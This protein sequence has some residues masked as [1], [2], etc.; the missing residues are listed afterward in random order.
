VFGLLLG[1][2]EILVILMVLAFWLAVIGGVI[3]IVLSVNK[4]AKHKPVTAPVQ[5]PAGPPPVATKTEIIPQKCP[6]CGTP[7]PTGALAGLCPACLLKLGAAADTVTDAKQ[8]AFNPPTV[9]ELAPLFPQL[10]ILELIGKGGMGAVYKARQKQLDR[11]VA[12]KILPPGIGDDPAFAERF[13]RE[14]KALAKLNHPGIVTLYEFG[15]VGRAGSP[16]PAAGGLPTDAGAHGVTRSTSE[17]ASGHQPSTL[18][19]QLFYFLMEFVDGVNL[20]QLLAGSRISAR[21]ALAIVPQIC[22]ALQFAHDQGIV[23]RDIKPE[24]ILMDRRGRVKVADFGLAKI[25]GTERGS[26]SRSG[27]EIEGAHKQP[28]APVT[29]Q[30]AADHRPAL[31]ELTDA[32]KVMGTP[33]YMSPEQIH[34]PGEVDH[35][36]DIYA[37]GVV[38]YQML[39]GE[40]PGKKLEAPS[41]KVQID[42]RLDEIVLRALEKKPELRYQQV[43]EV[44]TMVET[45]VATPDSSR[46]RGD[47]SQTSQTPDTKSQTPCS[48]SLLTSSPTNQ[49]A[50]FSRTA[51]FGACWTLLLILCFIL[52]NVGIKTFVL[53]PIG[54]LAVIGTTI[55]GWVAVA[56]I[57]RSAGKLHGLWLAVFDGLLFPLLALD[58]L[59]FVAVAFGLRFAGLG[60]KRTSPPTFPLSYLLFVAVII[61]ILLLLD[62]LIIR[63]VWHAVNQPAEI[64]TTESTQQKAGAARDIFRQPFAQV[65]G[66]RQK[67]DRFWRWFAVVVFAMV[68]IPFLISIVGL[69]AAIAIPSFVKARVKAQENAEMARQHSDRAAAWTDYLRLNQIIAPGVTGSGAYGDANFRYEVLF[70]ETSVALTVTYAKVTGVEYRVQTEDKAGKKQELE[71]KPH[72]TTVRPGDGQPS[73]E[74]KLMLSRTEFAGLAALILQKRDAKPDAAATRNLSFGPV[75]ER[76]MKFDKNGAT[77]FLDLDSDRILISKPNNTGE[78]PLFVTAGVSFSLAERMMLATSLVG[79]RPADNEVWNGLATDKAKAAFGEIRIAPVMSIWNLPENDLPKIFYFKTALGKIGLLQITGF[80]ENPRGVKIRYKL[81]QGLAA[82]E[83]NAQPAST[84]T[85]SPT[86]VP[87]EK[88]DLQKILDE[89]KTLMEEHKYEESLQR[90]LWHFNHA[91]EFGDSYQSVV[92]LTSGL[93]DW[94]EL[95]RRYPK[96]KQALIEIRDSR[97]QQLAAGQGY[98]E[99]LHEVQAINHELQA[100]DDTVALIKTVHAK[101]PKLTRQNYFWMED[102]LL[103]KGEYD[104]LLDCMPQTRFESARRGFEMQLASQQRMAEIRKQHPVPT[105]QFVGSFQPPDMGQMATNNFVGQVRKLVEILVA[106]DH[107]ADAEK[108][109]T[110]ALAVLADARLESAVSDA[111][112]KIGNPAPNSGATKTNSAAMQTK[113]SYSSFDQSSAMAP[114]ENLPSGVINFQNVDLEQVLKIYGAL[115]RRTVVQ[116]SLPAVN[117]N[118]RSETPLTRIE[119]LQLF[120]CVLAANGIAMVLSGENAVKAVPVA[121]AAGENPPEINLPWEALPDS[122]SP[123]SR[124][125]Q[126]KNLKALEVVPMLTP[127]AKLP[128]SIVVFQDRNLLILRDYASSIRQQLKL[129]ET[130]EQKQAQGGEKN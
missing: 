6:Q 92:R 127:L 38:F 62:W 41:K 70:D 39:T 93:S 52:T 115:S 88:P 18:N 46:R 8:S 116:G 69:L 45:I 74:E 60:W 117:L 106:T 78:S 121:T 105:P 63:R 80:T 24:N 57:R 22:D 110:Q 29:G 77:Q 72:V 125:V 49:G 58:G 33:Q 44:K 122:S 68:A 3:A 128:N 21:E 91:A 94:E 96:A 9:A 114:D 76:E 20:R 7:L 111:E 84:E 85:W 4:R 12:L 108:I 16:L 113:R 118:L 112:K 82:T 87:G 130:L 42:V 50:R 97:T 53:G 89:A 23:H 103:Q 30:S 2:W 27:D 35:R 81:V 119:S 17:A 65:F 107:K 100:D 11:I 31:Q 48:Q 102:L 47:E 90:H 55:L 101:D 59:I 37:L 129:L 71:S 1:G 25:V 126:L 86:F 99:M 124:T 14:A 19:S 15:Q 123:M 66:P 5:P 61:G 83:S 10:E 79:L 104:L 95:G 120:D 43:S 26:V 28:A 13:A 98:A 73:V 75:V 54:L 36:A 51:I 67:P 56:Q 64:P 32:G 40:L 34:A 109:R